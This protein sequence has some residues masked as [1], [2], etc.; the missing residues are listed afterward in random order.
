MRPDDVR[1]DVDEPTAGSDIPIAAELRPLE[2][3]LSDV[4]WALRRVAEGTYGRCQACGRPIG[5]ARLQ[6]RPATRFCLE[7]QSR[8]E[9][10]VRSA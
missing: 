4:E 8:L 6:A 5:T 3:E 2:A 9:R 1:V 7:D 10:E